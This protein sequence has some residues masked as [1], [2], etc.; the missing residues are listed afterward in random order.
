MPESYVEL[1]EKALVE[2]AEKL[3]KIK[4]NSRDDLRRE[5]PHG[6]R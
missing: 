4:S 3:R 2:I 1:D 5:K 6:K